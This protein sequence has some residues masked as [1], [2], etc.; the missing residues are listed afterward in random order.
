MI[1]VKH[2]TKNPITTMGE[3][4]GVCTNFT[5]ENKFY[6]VG[7]SCIK[8]GHGRVLEYPD[9]VLEISNYSARMIRELYTHISGV[10]R[11]QESTRYVKLDDFSYYIPD[12]IMYNK[13]ACDEYVNTMNVI[14]EVYDKL[15]NTHNISK[16]DTANILPLGMHTKI[17]LKINLRALFHLFE[18]RTC[19]RAYKEFRMFMTELKYELS[20]LDV[21]WNE[22][23]QMFKTKCDYSKVCKEQ[24]GSCGKYPNYKEGVE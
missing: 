14:K 16:E 20:K 15:I 2:F 11:L 12:S 24:R 6:N 8:S 4:A 21:E 3:I 7:L 22:L 18:E 19:M 17:V 5:D 23:T 13:E 1:K 9:V 10:S